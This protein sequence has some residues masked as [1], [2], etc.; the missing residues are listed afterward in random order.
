MKTEKE[1]LQTGRFNGSRYI[2]EARRRKGLLF[3]ELHGHK[4]TL[5]IR[6]PG[7]RGLGWQ[8]EIV[9]GSS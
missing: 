4:M 2:L 5:R 6:K 1:S 8:I 3:R 7:S 9:T